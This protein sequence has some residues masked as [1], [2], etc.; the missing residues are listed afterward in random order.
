MMSRLR[1]GAGQATSEYLGALLI[2]SVVIAALALTD[3]GERISYESRILICKIGGG[4]DC[5]SIAGN[6]DAPAA[7]KCVVTSSDK[8]VQAS[9]KVFVVKLEG[10]VT[11]VYRVSADGTTY[12]T[13]KANA[14]AGLE[15]STPGVEAGSDD[16]AASSPKGEFSV[17]GK[18]EF[19]RTWKFASQNDADE[20]IGNVVDKVKAKADLVP[21]FLQDD[22]D[23]DLPDQDSDT[24]YGGVNVS[25]SVSAGGG[26]YANAGGGVEAGLGATYS[27]NGDV[28][29]FFKAKANVSGRA[30]NSLAGGFGA[31]GEGEVVVAM[32]YDRNGNEKTMKVTGVGTLTGGLDL[33]GNAEDLSG[34][35]GAINKAGGSGVGQMGKRIEFESE[36]DLTDPANRAAA[37]AFLDGENPDTGEYVPL[38]TATSDLL[39]RFDAAARTNVRL[40]DVDKTELGVD[41]D[42]SVV[43]FSA[44]YSE[45]DA[46]L[47]DAWFD[48]GPGGFQPWFDC[49][50]AAT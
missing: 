2:V 43:G 39:G 10:G 12:V 19:A 47:T 28:T 11:G 29:Y 23:Y 21:N 30:G 38:A 24:I 4:E 33:R 42:G 31:N 1:S 3:V 9:V 8:S 5:A 49:S 36:L 6:P 50:G 41:I 22:D 34:L 45:S 37:R 13:L 16:V 17:T 35:L 27:A 46:N 44:K 18:G 48:P 7:S 25:G 32:T 20:F 26:A 15:F 40:Y 14:G